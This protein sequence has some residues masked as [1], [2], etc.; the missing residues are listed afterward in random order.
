MSRLWLP[1][2]PDGSA[3]CLGFDGSTVDDWTALRAETREGYQFTP[4]YGNGRPTIWNPA[5]WS[6]R[7]PESEVESALDEIHDRFRVARG[8]Y[9]P[10]QWETPVKVAWPLR[11][12]EQRVIAWETYRARPMHE[13]LERFRNDLAAGRITHDGCPLTWQAMDNA[14]QVARSGDRYVLAKPS[15]TQ[16]IDPTMAS[17]LAHE[18]ASDMRAEDWPDADSIMYV[19]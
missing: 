7:V 3:I 17:V 5:E 12:G 14:R 15:Q 11:F 18:A 19:F 9:D 16:K 10:P 4:R 6:G 2:P 1:E 13:A 8:Y